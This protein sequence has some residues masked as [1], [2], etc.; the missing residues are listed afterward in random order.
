MFNEFIYTYYQW[1]VLFLVIAYVSGSP[2]MQLP[3]SSVILLLQ[4]LAIRSSETFQVLGPGQALH[5]VSGEDLVLPCSLKPAI[6][7]E[8]MMV[9]WFRL[10][11]QEQQRP[12]VHL[13]EDGRD[14][15]ND[16]IQSFKGRTSLF[17]EELKRGNTS[18]KLSNTQVSDEGD[19]KCVVESKSHYDDAVVQI[20]IRGIG[21]TPF[22]SLEGYKRDGISLVCESEGWMPEPALDWLDAE[23]RSL[24]AEP[25][26]VHWE[27]DGFRV[28]RRLI[29][30]ENDSKRYTCRV[31]QRDD[32]WA[33]DKDI[34]KEAMLHISG[35]WFIP[36]QPLEVPS[37]T[38]R[39]IVICLAH[40][41]TLI[42]GLLLFVLYRREYQRKL[43][44]YE[45]ENRQLT[46]RV[47][48]YGKAFLK[49]SLVNCAMPTLYK[50]F[51]PF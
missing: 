46:G 23:G 37:S 10:N 39:I 29:I 22:V 24:T 30:H 5:A 14:Q 18:L 12:S 16:Q 49:S 15:N 20:F 43:S 2:L 35:E 45:N 33:T 40:T 26:E 13:Y 42:G 36:L 27:S 51:S 28:K 21:R 19:Y 50:T 32:R 44:T 4:C 7:A 3:C 25:T 11:Y 34:V 48:H 31:S 8:A 41:L 17:K 9:H 1:S 6:S 38:A 47:S